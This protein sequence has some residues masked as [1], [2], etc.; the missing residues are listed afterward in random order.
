MSPVRKN[1]SHFLLFKYH[2]ICIVI[3]DTN[4]LLRY[5]ENMLNTDLFLIIFKLYVELNSCL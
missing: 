5:L 4:I 1:I 3:F 2:Y